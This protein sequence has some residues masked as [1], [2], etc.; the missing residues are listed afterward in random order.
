M[1]TN[2]SA[3]GNRIGIRAGEGI[4]SES[5]GNKD[6]AA[7]PL[8]THGIEQANQAGSC[9]LDVVS[10]HGSSEKWKVYFYVSPYVRTRSTLQEIGRTFPRNSVLGVKEECRVREQDFGNFQ[11]A[12]RMKR[13]YRRRTKR[14]ERPGAGKRVESIRLDDREKQNEIRI[15][16]KKKQGYGYHDRSPSIKKNLYKS[17]RVS[18]AFKHP[19]YAGIENDIAFLIENDDDSQFNHTKPEPNQGERDRR[20]GT[21]NQY[22]QQH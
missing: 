6:D 16:P 1:T 13:W 2:A 14:S 5:Q 11:V 20:V 4:I 19:K 15:W 17:L 3:V 21:G 8:T 7:I 18:G 9:I 22:H 12:Q 10:G